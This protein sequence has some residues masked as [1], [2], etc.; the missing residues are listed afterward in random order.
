MAKRKEEGIRIEQHFGKQ[1]YEYRED[2]S[3]YVGQIVGECRTRRNNFYLIM[4]SMI[5]IKRASS[6]R[7]ERSTIKPG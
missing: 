4:Q 2:N 6:N 3:F 7:I 5:M 1:I